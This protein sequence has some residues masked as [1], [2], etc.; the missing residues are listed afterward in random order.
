[1]S[2][3]PFVVGKTYIIHLPPGWIYAGTIERVTDEHLILRDAVWIEGLSA[4][5]YQLALATTAAA[6]KTVA[7]TAN[8]LPDGAI[9]RIDCVTHAAPCA[10]DMRALA[11]A[12]MASAIKGAA[13]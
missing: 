13:K 7:T 3:S 9:A 6:Q 8:P 2:E 4:D 10:L 5:V 12:R 11:R 1:M